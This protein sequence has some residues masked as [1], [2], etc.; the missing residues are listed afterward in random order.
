MC[1]ALLYL[2]PLSLTLVLPITFFKHLNGHCFGY[3]A[4][5]LPLSR[6]DMYTPLVLTGLV[7]AICQTVL[8]ATADEWRS[9][10]IYQVLTDRFARSDHST[11]ATCKTADRVYC[12]GD[13]NGITE[14]LDYIQG[15]GFDAIWI[16]PITA[17]IPTTTPYGDAYHGYWQTN[18]FNV[19]DH[20]GNVVD[21]QYLANTLHSRGMVCNLNTWLVAQTDAQAVSHGRYRDQSLR[22]GWWSGHD[23]LYA[24]DSVCVAGSLPYILSSQLHKDPGSSKSL[25]DVARVR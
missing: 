23:R 11:T 9:R 10:S 8:A 13:W 16:S 4:I 1:I 6:L 22:L 19:N 17:Q 12:G 3:T 25:P 14:H 24:V 18:I 2:Y 15:M 7:S 21:L 5:S 20:F